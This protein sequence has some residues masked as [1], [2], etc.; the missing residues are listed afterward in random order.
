VQALALALAGLCVGSFLATAAARAADGFRGMWLGRSRCPACGAALRWPELVP[1]LSWLLLRGRCRHCGASIVAAYPLTELA[2][3]LVGAIPGLLLPAP[4][5]AVAALLGWWLLSLALIDL[6]TFRLPD[7][8]TLPLLPL[9]LA[10]TLAPAPLGLAMPSPPLAVL[11]GAA[12]FLLLLA[13]RWAHARLRGREGLGL[14]DAK[15]AAAAGLWLGPEWLPWLFLLAGGLGLALAALRERS[16]RGDLAVPFGP[17][18]ALAFWILLL[19]AQ[20]G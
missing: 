12:A 20:A 9:G 2:A 15:L 10:A 5:A 4:A 8:L 16:L 18:L 14:G 13:L 1:L 17:P 11:G 6:A 3:A 7:P 19:A